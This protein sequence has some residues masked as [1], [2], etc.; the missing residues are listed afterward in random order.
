MDSKEGA[1]PKLGIGCVT[2]RLKVAEFNDRGVLGG[3]LAAPLAKRIK[4]EGKRNEEKPLVSRGGSN[5]VNIG[6]YDS[7]G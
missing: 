6:Y 1:P 3:W 5:T 2:L 4:K 7:V